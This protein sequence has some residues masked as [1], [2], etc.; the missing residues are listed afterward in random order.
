MKN[1]ETG[2]STDSETIQNYCLYL[3]KV[4]EIQSEAV[5]RLADCE[6]TQAIEVAAMLEDIANTF[7][8]M[9]DAIRDIA[10]GRKTYQPNIDAL[11][12]GKTDIS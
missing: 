1:F 3:Q 10:L 12:P 5:R 8:N 2:I 7:L 9:S 6:G 11:V 4:M